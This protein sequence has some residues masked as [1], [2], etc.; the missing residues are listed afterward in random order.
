ME[1]INDQAQSLLDELRQMRL[2]RSWTQEDLAKAVRYSAS[3]VGM[4][5]T[6]TRKPPPGFWERVDEAFQTGGMFARQAKRLSTPKWKADWESAE[7]EAVALRSYQPLVVPGLLQTE[8]YARAVLTDAGLLSRDDVERHLAQRLAR[9]EIL[10]RESPPQFTA[11]IDYSVLRRPVGGPAVMLEQIQAIIKACEEPHVRVHIV[12]DTVGAYAG[13]NGPFV[14]A[15]A[16]D[17][18]ITGYLDNQVKGHLVDSA[19]DLAAVQAAWEAVRGEA[20]P[21]RQ[22]TDLMME[23]A[24]TWI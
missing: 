2:A 17:Q 11:V 20:L 16:Q 12:P 22:S 24:E 13:L 15:T 7:R 1:L 6:G 23:V 14:L 4:I 21:H 19:E 5:E 9:Q 3:L 10:R 18:S 8:A